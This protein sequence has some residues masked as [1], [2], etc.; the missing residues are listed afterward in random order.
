MKYEKTAGAV[1]TEELAVYRGKWADCIANFGAK[2]SIAALMD[3]LARP[4]ALAESGHTR[5]YQ[6]LTEEFDRQLVSCMWCNTGDPVW[7]QWTEIPKGREM[8]AAYDRFHPL[9]TQRRRKRDDQ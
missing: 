6:L 9:S 5:A 4:H 8:R 7:D 3:V 2:E 1:K